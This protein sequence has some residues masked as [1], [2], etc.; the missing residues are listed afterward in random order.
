M[1]VCKRGREHVWSWLVTFGVLGWMG[2][3]WRRYP[4]VCWKLNDKN[5]WRGQRRDSQCSRC[6][7]YHLQKSIPNIRSYLSITCAFERYVSVDCIIHEIVW[8]TKWF[9]MKSLCVAHIHPIAVLKTGSECLLRSISL[10]HTHPY[11]QEKMRWNEK[12]WSTMMTMTVLA[13]CII[14]FPVIPLH[15]TCSVWRGKMTFAEFPI[16]IFHSRFGCRSENVTAIETE[17]STSLF[18]HASTKYNGPALHRIWLVGAHHQYASSTCIVPLDDNKRYGFFFLGNKHIPER[19]PTPA[20]TMPNTWTVRHIRMPL[21]FRVWH[22]FPSFFVLWIQH[23]GI[24]SRCGLLFCL[25]FTIKSIRR[26][27]L[28]QCS[29]ATVVALLPSPTWAK[30]LPHESRIPLFIEQN[31]CLDQK[32]L[33]DYI[34]LMAAK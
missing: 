24:Q 26:I 27:H 13:I 33:N 12:V 10:S 29:M 21:E 3:D 8:D 18:Q 2:L 5:R 11:N 34:D 17:W 20:L 23:S 30:Y 9:L 15:C 16:L 31:T 6:S 14:W 19:A 25:I 7:H 1:D 4:R 28:P 22:F 32:I